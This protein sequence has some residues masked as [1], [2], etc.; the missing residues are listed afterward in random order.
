VRK[1]V[2]ARRL[3]VNRQQHLE[4]GYGRSFWYEA[5]NY[6]LSSFPAACSSAAVYYSIFTL[7]RLWHLFGV[8]EQPNGC[9]SVALGISAS[10][11]CNLA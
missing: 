2:I 10:H 8:D 9:S 4:A 1:R 11:R 7:S 3:E 5:G 6:R